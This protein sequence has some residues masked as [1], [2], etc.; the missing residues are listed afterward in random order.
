MV[1]K[2]FACNEIYTKVGETVRGKNVFIVQTAT[3][4]VNED[5]MEL[6]LLC[7]TMKRSFAKSV[8]VVLPHFGYSRQDRISEPRE[9]V[10]AKLIAD[11]IVKSGA[12]HIVTFTLHSDQIQ[13][14]F[15]IPVDNINAQK[16]FVDYFKKK[17]LRDAVVVSPDAGGAKSAKNFAVQLGFPLAILH[18]SRPRHNVS[19]VTHVVGDVR[20][21]VPIIY[22]DI[23]DT[24]GSV[25]TA[26]EALVQAGALDKVYLAATHPV[27]SN[28]ATERLEKAN[29]KEVVVTN[30]IPISPEKQ[31]SN[32]KVLSLAPLIA[33]VIQNIT[34]E[35]SVSNLYL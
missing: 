15:D 32:L 12:D 21:K 27:F 16:L 25:C 23:I 3:Q 2:R 9:T 17:N 28:P 14:F 5:Y 13:G 26:K 11:L 31:L 1:I 10:S 22:D 8:H 6:F 35:K 7:D 34:K 4:D 19:E 30:S 24:A 33:K 20:N 18:K 29:F